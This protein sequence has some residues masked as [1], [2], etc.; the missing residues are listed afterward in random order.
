MFH[1][2]GCEQEV[3]SCASSLSESQTVTGLW[4]LLSPNLKL[5][6][7]LMKKHYLF[8]NSFFHSVFGEANEAAPCC[9]EPE[10]EHGSFPPTASK[11]C[12]H[13]PQCNQH[14]PLMT[15]VFQRDNATFPEASWDLTGCSPVAGRGCWDEGFHHPRPSKLWKGF[16]SGHL[17]FPWHLRINI[18]SLISGFPSLWFL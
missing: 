18:P 9:S 3:W 15:T 12:C 16:G 11:T 13:M 2:A 7:A 17:A 4:G 14:W 1:G 5:N 10:A 8:F 6:R